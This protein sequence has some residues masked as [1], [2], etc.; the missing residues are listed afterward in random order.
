MS[1]NEKHD[2]LPG[3]E[4]P[5]S[6]GESD[7]RSIR[8]RRRRGN[9]RFKPYH[10]MGPEEQKLHDMKM[11]AK[12]ATRRSE[13]LKNGRPMAP[14]NTTQFLLNDREQ[15]ADMDAADEAAYIAH[16]RSR[17]RSLSVGSEHYFEEG[18][19]SGESES[20]KEE[21]VNHREFEDVYEEIQIDRCVNMTKEDLTREVLGA[22]K[23]NAVIMSELERV[24]HENNRLR[25]ML[26]DHGID[27][28]RANANAQV[29]SPPTARVA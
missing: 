16:E 7:V 22:T 25:Q 9:K 8:K 3:R 15:R 11:D 23:D 20:D 24:K 4:R 18:S 27:V 2:T 1:S 26:Q 14:Y 13:R 10:D 28:A 29:P 17:V 6:D 5:A 19:T 12:A 21:E